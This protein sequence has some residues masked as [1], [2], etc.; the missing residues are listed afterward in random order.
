MGQYWELINIDARRQLVSRGRGRKLWEVLHNRLPE[1]LVDLLKV[2]ALKRMRFAE[3]VVGEVKGRA[4]TKNKACKLFALPQEILDRVTAYVQ[5]GL[6][7][8]CLAL[9]H[10]YFFRL[11]A[12]RVREAVIDDE[13]PWAGA[14]IILV[15]DYATS[16]PSS[17][18]AAETHAFITV[19]DDE[20]D[21]DLPPSADE[22]AFRARNPLYS[23]QK[24]S[25]SD[26]VVPVDWAE[27][28]ARIGAMDKSRGWKN[29]RYEQV[30]SGVR[31]ARG[32][33]LTG[34]EMGVLDRLFAPSSP[35]SS[36]SSSSASVSV[37]ASSSSAAATSSTTNKNLATKDE[38]PPPS[39]SSSYV[40]RNLTKRLFVRDSVLGHRSSRYR[41]SLGEALCARVLWTADPSGT[42]GLGCRGKWAGDRF[43]IIKAAEI[44][45][46]QGI[47]E[48]IEDEHYSY[49]LFSYTKDE[50][51]EEEW[52]D[53]TM[54]WKD[55][56]AAALR[57]SRRAG[58]DFRMDGKRC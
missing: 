56:S 23:M 12:E 37:S 6:D 30:A 39:S 35:S 53:E 4:M 18:T 21:P 24:G 43:D 8:I 42:M 25:V 14:R 20:D 52:R 40:L 58:M 13:A 11:L 28:W 54:A 48:G 29:M 15:G 55:V 45:V 36:P 34:E 1:M 5:E 3:G 26:A 51:E 32:R 31:R 38:I 22:R 19:H 27:E 9:S 17:V 49:N 10:S 33:R 57:R 16:V 7:A 2:P 46:V 41:Y 47:D 50:E 44:G